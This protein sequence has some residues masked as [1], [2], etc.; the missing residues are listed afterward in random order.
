MKGI[1]VVI[2]NWNGA[3]R[4]KK[5]LPQINKKIKQLGYPYEILVVDDASTDESLKVLESFSF[6][7]V[8]SCDKN[9]GFS[10][11]ANKGVWLAQYELVFI[12]SNDIVPGDSLE[13]LFDHFKDHS[14]FAVSPEVRWSGTEEF[15]YGKRAVDWKNGCFRVE[16]RKQTKLPCYTLF[17]CGGSAVFRR[18]R[19][20]DLGGFDNI[21]YPFYWEEIDL[22]YRAWK[23]GYKVIHEPRAVVLNSNSGVIKK[24]FSQKYIKL[25]SGR[26]SYIFLWKNISS[27]KLFSDHVLNLFPS[28]IKDIK[29]GLFRFPIC[30]FLALLKIPSVLIKRVKE[31]HEKV[32]TDLEVIRFVNSDI[33][34]L[35]R[36]SRKAGL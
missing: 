9:E 10:K 35:D 8:F 25:I 22:S 6:V 36:T 4:L 7:R 34:V 17:A 21:Y 28:L 12:I 1:S 14:V 2:P 3:D 20:L 19:F 23:R 15:A 32:L 31:K 18:S 11:N 33:T 30:C 16:E 26:N 27:R 29:A 13:H 5:N 24:Y